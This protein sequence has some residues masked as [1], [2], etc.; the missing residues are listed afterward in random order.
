M[1]L[2][3]EEERCEWNRSSCE[4][5]GQSGGTIQIYKKERNLLTTGLEGFWKFFD[6]VAS[7]HFS[8]GQGKI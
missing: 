8:H 4:L 7:N 3:M 5:S 1:G 2:E 6:Q